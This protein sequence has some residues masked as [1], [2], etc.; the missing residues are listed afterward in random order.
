M[1]KKLKIPKFKNRDQEFEF[2]SKLY[3]SNY[4]ERSDFMPVSFPNLK[5]TA[6]IKKL[7]KK[8][9]GQIQDGVLK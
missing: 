8:Q 3:L 2:W 1:K 7:S 4:F 9:H 6:N 5:L